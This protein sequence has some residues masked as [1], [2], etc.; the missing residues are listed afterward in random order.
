VA[1]A[2]AVA[3][4]S[5]GCGGGGDKPA[6]ASP[7]PASAPKE[8]V[9]VKLRLDWFANGTHIGFYVAK[10]K[11]WYAE[12]G[13]DVTIGEGQGSTQ[14][15]QVVA[16]GR[17][18]FGFIAPA[19]T[20]PAIAKGARVKTVAGV[21]QKNP[22][23]IVV[24]ADA[25]INTPKDL[26][27]TTCSATSFGYIEKLA[28]AFYKKVGVD[29]S[30][31]KQ[32]AISPESIVP[33]LLSGKFKAFCGALFEDIN[34]DENGVPAKIFR[35][36]DYGVNVMAHAIVANQE[37]IDSSPEAVRGFVQASM[38]GYQWAF[39]NPDAAIALLKEASPKIKVAEELKV[40][41][42]VKAHIATEHTQGK[43]LGWMAAE[44]WQASV[45]LMSQYLDLKNAPALDQIYTN[46][47]V[48]QQ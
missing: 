1:L 37:I 6:A 38:R 5:A 34:M 28:P 2:A 27:G 7:E 25:G 31:I 19:A 45:D 30:K 17:E 15:V 20:I 16:S 42:L 9:K 10:A 41:A 22:G 14:T 35:L 24:R 26:P 33:T 11:G 47:F 8:T 39:D 48:A 29:A 43:P 13:L 40:V 3:L 18:Q 23:G 21:L 32:V 12:K 4:A 46:E 36:S 44:D